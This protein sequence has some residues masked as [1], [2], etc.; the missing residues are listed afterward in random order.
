MI[1]TGV[2][3]LALAAVV[4]AAVGAS[5]SIWFCSNV[6]HQ[7]MDDAIIAY[8]DSPHAK[9]SCIQ[10]HT[11]I[12]ADPVTF[13]IDKA[14]FGID[15]VYKVATH[16][17]ELPVNDGSVVAFETPRKQCTQCHSPNRRVTPGR[18]LKIDHEA[19]AKRDIGCTVCHNRVAHPETHDL[20]LAGN[21]RHD[22]FMQMGAC[23][24]C[25]GQD[26]TAQGPGRCEACH[27]AAFELRPASHT[28]E[29]FYKPFGDSHLHAEMAKKDQARMT[30]AEESAS[31]EHEEGGLKIPQLD[32][33]SSCGQC[34]AE[35]FCN[36]CHGLEIPHPAAFRD[37]HDK[38]ASA[39]PA[40]CAPCH[41]SSKAS[42]PRKTCDDCH[43]KVGDPSK[44]WFPQ[45]SRLATKDAGPCLDCHDP[46][47]CESC[48]VSGRPKTPY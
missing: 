4:I 10:C 16:T 45:H 14:E 47:Y 19:H 24:R 22:D 17:F 42:S 5:S 25:H 32:A 48:H 1:L 41:A 13:L 46:M 18:G 26:A 3:V 35:K 2:S 7:V 20:V 12:G 37:D 21:R 23:F 8:H 34:H 36:D 38:V 33:V 6:C 43:H 30:K 9:I 15:G 31:R 29:G 44:P 39:N 27:T 11:H 28:Q 40:A